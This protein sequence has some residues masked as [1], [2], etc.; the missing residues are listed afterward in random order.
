MRWDACAYVKTNIIY[1]N[2][3]SLSFSVCHVTYA[4]NLRE[5]RECNSLQFKKVEWIANSEKRHLD[6]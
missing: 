4:R 1:L 6:N 2:Q 5:I 3:S